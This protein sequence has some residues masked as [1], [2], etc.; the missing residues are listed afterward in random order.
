MKHVYN[1]LGQCVDN[2]VH[3]LRKE[4]YGKHDAEGNL[5]CD[6]FGNPLPAWLK[7]NSEVDGWGF[8]KNGKLTGY[9]QTI[10]LPK[11]TMIARYGNE[12][13]K[14]T[15]PRGTPYEMLS[16]PYIKE[17]MEYHEYKVIADGVQV[18]C[19][20]NK[21]E[22]Y[23]AFEQPGGGIQFLH[24]H[25]IAEELAAHKIEEATEWITDIMNAV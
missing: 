24:L 8:A 22:I 9:Y 17:T 25:S 2:V 12:A 20:V 4:S 19:I 13:G 18:K 1:Y 6:R 10:I 11:G 21:G 3:G 14:L 15:A 7:E 16:L 5:L 23:P